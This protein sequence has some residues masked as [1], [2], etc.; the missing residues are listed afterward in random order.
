MVDACQK[1]KKNHMARVH[2]TMWFRNE[3][4]LIFLGQM[5]GI[6][7]IELLDPAGS[8]DKLLLAGEKR[9]TGG[10]NFHVYFLLYRTKFKLA[11][12][13]TLRS[14]FMVFRMNF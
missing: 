6:L 4:L 11:A 14:N 3:L 7:L 13:G 5:L 12:A 2:L 10:T 1:D 8:I 9:M